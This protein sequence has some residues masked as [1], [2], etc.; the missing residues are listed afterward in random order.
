MTHV[1]M[2]YRHADPLFSETLA[3]IFFLKRRERQ[4]S[5]VV[6]YMDLSEHFLAKAEE[7]TINQ[8][9]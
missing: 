3:M 1:F 2:L 6:I 4:D 5:Y 9:A 7:P 8:K